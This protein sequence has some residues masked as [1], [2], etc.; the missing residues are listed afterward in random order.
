MAFLVERKNSPTRDRLRAELEGKFPGMIWCEY[1]PLGTTLA[2]EAVSAA[3]GQGIRLLPNF[4]QA[5][6]IVA[7]DSE[8]LNQSDKG[9]GFRPRFLPAPQPGPEGRADESP[10]RR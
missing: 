2:R 6:V 3:F 8:F 4:Q 9:V 7:L 1:E 5:D 10:L